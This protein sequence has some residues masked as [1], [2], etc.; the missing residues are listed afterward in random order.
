[1]TGDYLFDATLNGVLDSADSAT[2]VILSDVLMRRRAARK[3]QE[4][5]LGSDVWYPGSSEQVRDQFFNGAFLAEMLRLVWGIE[6]GARVLNVGSASGLT[7][8]ALRELGFDAYGIESGRL[9]HAR[10]P[11][12]YREFNLFGDPADLPFPDGHFDAVIETGLCDLPRAGIAPAIAEMRRVSRCGVMLGSIVTDLTIEMIERYDLLASVKTL[13]SR[14]DW[15]DE[16]FAQGFGHALTDPERLAKV[17]KCAQA[18]GAGPGHWYEEP[19][20]VLYCFYNV[21]AI[22]GQQQLPIPQPEHQ[23]GHGPRSLEKVEVR[24]H[25]IATVAI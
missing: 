14:W 17:W 23:T 7:V 10:T 12:A 1:V 2:D 21:E 3:A 19:E 20:S 13:A 5:T 6:P 25:R 4:G 24:Q 16:F 15:A 22:P 18:C 9:A 11:E 8:A